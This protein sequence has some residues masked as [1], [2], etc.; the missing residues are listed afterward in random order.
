MKR[1]FFFEKTDYKQTTPHISDPNF[2]P[3]AI[4]Y[5]CV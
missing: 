1:V 2:V 4:K 3:V 5:D